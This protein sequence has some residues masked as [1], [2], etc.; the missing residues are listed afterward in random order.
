MDTF[1]KSFNEILVFCGVSVYWFRKKT[2]LSHVLGYF[3]IFTV[4][5]SIMADYFSNAKTHPPKP[6]ELPEHLL[7]IRASVGA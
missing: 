7:F 6:P 3:L 2:I 4:V 1:M 5:A